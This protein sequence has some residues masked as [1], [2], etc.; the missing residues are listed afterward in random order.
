VSYSLSLRSLTIGYE[1][2]KLKT[3]NIHY[4]LV[5]CVCLVEMLICLKIFIS[6][7]DNVK[8]LVMS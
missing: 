8:G 6:T 2:V 1:I 4:A 7:D 3:E 5:N